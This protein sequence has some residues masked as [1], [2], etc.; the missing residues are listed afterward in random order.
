MPRRKTSLIRMQADALRATQ[1]AAL[2]IAARLPLIAKATRGPAIVP[3]QELRTMVNEKVAAA[4]LG[5]AA[6]SFAWGNF[7]TRAMFGS[8]RTPL[9]A[10]HGLAS[11]AEAAMKPAR[12]TVRAN[13]RRLS[14]KG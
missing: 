7:W 4:M 3:P 10:A 14:R 9:D 5:T 2:T 8:I 12:R 6:A 13:A 1:D 11:V